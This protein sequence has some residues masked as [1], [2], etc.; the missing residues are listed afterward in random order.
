MAGRSTHGPLTG[1]EKSEG[2]SLIAIPTFN[3][4]EESSSSSSE[5]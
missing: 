3:L 5:L 1:D 2:A 4:E